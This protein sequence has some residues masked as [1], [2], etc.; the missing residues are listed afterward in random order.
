MSPY[1]EQSSLRKV[2]VSEI[3]KRRGMSEPEVENHIKELVEQGYLKKVG[4][5]TYDVTPLLAIM[6]DF[7]E[8]NRRKHK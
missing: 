8:P 5:N 3:A 1:V 6:G 2:N 4:K 7:A